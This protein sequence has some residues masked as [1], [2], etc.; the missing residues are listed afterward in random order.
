MFLLMLCCL[1]GAAACGKTPGA[2]PQSDQHPQQTITEKS[3]DLK[4]LDNEA[5]EDQKKKDDDDQSGA[6]R[7]RPIHRG[8]N[9]KRRKLPVQPVP[10]PGPAPRPQL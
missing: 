8:K 6:E 3:D 10:T 1:I 2:T 5:D 4:Q 7:M 9:K